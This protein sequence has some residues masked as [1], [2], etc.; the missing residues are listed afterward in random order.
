MGRLVFC[1]KKS[2]ILDDK[3]EKNF[4]NKEKNKIFFQKLLT[5][6]TNSYTI[7]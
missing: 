3:N 5:F 2:S 4:K 1:L 6:M 7:R